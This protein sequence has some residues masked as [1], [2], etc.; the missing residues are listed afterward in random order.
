MTNTIREMRTPVT[1][2]AHMDTWDNNMIRLKSLLNESVQGKTLIS[3]DIQPEYEPY[4]HFSINDYVNFLNQNYPLVNSMVFLYNGHETIGLISEPDYKMWWLDHGLEEE[5]VNY[6]QFY[7]KGYAFFR[8]CM[9][10]SIDEKV[11][12]NF[13]RF[14]YQ[15]GVNDSRDMDRELWRKYLKQY[16]KTD[17]TDLYDL[18]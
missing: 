17:K 1:L 15:N 6:S 14:M 13:V 7:D 11:I 10:K 5:I 8:Y 2:T 9:D 16:K 4:F 12:V 18:S 3:V